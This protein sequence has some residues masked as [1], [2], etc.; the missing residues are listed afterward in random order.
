[1][2]SGMGTL[3]AIWLSWLL[4]LAPPAP[5]QHAASASLDFRVIAFHAIPRPHHHHFHLH[6]KWTYTIAKSCDITSPWDTTSCPSR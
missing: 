4:L 2:L 5:V 6:S 3:G 1:M